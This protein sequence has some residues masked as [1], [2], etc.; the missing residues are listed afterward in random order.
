MLDRPKLV[1]DLPDPPVLTEAD[2]ERLYAQERAWTE[3]LR[4]KKEAMEAIRG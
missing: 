3:W 4:E 1:S 2:I